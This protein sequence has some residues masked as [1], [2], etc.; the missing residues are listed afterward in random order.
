MANDELQQSLYEQ[1]FGHIE[2]ADIF[3]V[4]SVQAAKGTPLYDSAISLLPGARSIVILGNE[5]FPEVVSLVSP[6][7]H[8]GEASPGDLYGP[9]VEYISGRLASA[10]YDIAKVYRR[11]GYCV[12]PLPARGTPSDPRFLQ[13]ILSFKHT[14][15]F[16][17]LGRIGHNTLLVTPQFGPRV[18]LACLLTDADIPSTP[19]SLSDPCEDC[20]EPCVTNCPAGALSSPPPGQ[21]YAINKF[22][23]SAFYSSVG[24]C[25]SCMSNC[26]AGKI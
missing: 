7:R 10:M 21:R 1:A 12:L 14:A 25:T 8:V 3:G 2:D 26:I 17:G 9:H 19:K 5:I 24:C 20:S 22:A 18:R 6:E 15:E 16:A 23:C 4:A 11:A 13:G